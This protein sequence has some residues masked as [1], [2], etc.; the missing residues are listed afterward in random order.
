MEKDQK[1]K[2]EKPPYHKLESNENY[3]PSYDGLQSKEF[4]PSYDGLKSK[5]FTPS[6]EGLKADNKFKPTY[7][8]PRRS[9]LTLPFRYYKTTLLLI[10]FIV[11]V[12]LITTFL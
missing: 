6:Y 5:K 4:V 10:V 2:A 7:G 3:T 8:R 9:I 12:L 1:P 11:I